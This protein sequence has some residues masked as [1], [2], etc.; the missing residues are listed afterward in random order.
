MIRDKSLT[1]LVGTFD[2]G[3]YYRQSWSARFDWRLKLRELGIDATVKDGSLNL[4]V[5]NKREDINLLRVAGV[6][7]GPEPCGQYGYRAYEWIKN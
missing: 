6:I 3:L 1:I 4:I 2:E 7:R 5:F